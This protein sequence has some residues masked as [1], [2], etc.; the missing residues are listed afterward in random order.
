MP[1]FARRTRQGGSRL[2]GACIGLALPR[3][4]LRLPYGRHTVPLEAFDFEEMPG[5]PIHTSYLWGNPAFACALV[6]SELSA[7][8]GSFARVPA[9]LRLSGMPLHVFRSDGETRTRPCTEVLL[10]E[11]DCQTLLRNGVLPLAATQSS[12]EIV[13]P[14]MRSIADPPAALAGFPAAS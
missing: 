3:F 2:E 4:L 11:D 10:T 9:N 14:L 1:S 8:Q 7:R 5:E 13:F 12:D 6:L